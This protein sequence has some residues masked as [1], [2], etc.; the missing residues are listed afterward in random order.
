MLLNLNIFVFNEGT[1]NF[2]RF[3]WALGLSNSGF[4]NY[5]ILQTCNTHSWQ[6]IAVV[7]N[8]IQRNNKEFQA[9][10]IKPPIILYRFLILHI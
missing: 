6:E 5:G 7:K 3:Q 9:E 10:L 2:T 1:S 4:A 8:N